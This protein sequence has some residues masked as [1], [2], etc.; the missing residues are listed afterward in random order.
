MRQAHPNCLRKCPQITLETTTSRR[1]IS[2][3]AKQEL[4]DFRNHTNNPQETLREHSFILEKEWIW[5]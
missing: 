2:A 4:C 1:R 3:A 5:I